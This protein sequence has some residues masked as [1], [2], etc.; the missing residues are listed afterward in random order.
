M[1]RARGRGGENTARAPGGSEKVPG[2]SCR[3]GNA[4]GEFLADVHRYH[5]T[6]SAAG[7]QT[8]VACVPKRGMIEQACHRNLDRR[9]KPQG[10][11]GYG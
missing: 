4:G 7:I 3:K 5:L 6:Q 1:F 2:L 10:G 8:S 9:A 11:E